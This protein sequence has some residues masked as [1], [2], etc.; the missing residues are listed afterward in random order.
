MSSEEPSRGMEPTQGKAEQSN[1]EQGNS[2]VSEWLI[3]QFSELFH[4]GF[5]VM[6]DNTLP[7]SLSQCTSQFSAARLQDHP[8]TEKCGHP[9]SLRNRTYFKARV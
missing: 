9:V 4:L 7:R 8:D 3:S 2:D 5:P 1:E 6:G